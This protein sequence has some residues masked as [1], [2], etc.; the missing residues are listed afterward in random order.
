MI[1]RFRAMAPKGRRFRWATVLLMTVGVWTAGHAASLQ[2]TDSQAY[3]LMISEPNRPFSASYQ[4]L[5]NS[6]VEICFLGCTMTLLATGQTVEVGPHDT[7]VIHDGAMT[8]TRP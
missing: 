1:A 8:V 5:E 3:N 2:N 4:V 7:V 6:Q